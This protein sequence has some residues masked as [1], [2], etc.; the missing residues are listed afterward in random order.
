ARLAALRRYKFF[1]GASAPAAPEPRAADIIQAGPTPDSLSAGLSARESFAQDPSA[2]GA[3]QEKPSRENLTSEDPAVADFVIEA[4]VALP[5][6]LPEPIAHLPSPPTD[7]D[8]AVEPPQDILKEIPTEEVETP[9][10]VL[11][12]RPPGDAKPP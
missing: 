5:T 11:P 12:F 9:K 2:A 7:L 8:N 4:D 1:G 10:N 3:P 6:E